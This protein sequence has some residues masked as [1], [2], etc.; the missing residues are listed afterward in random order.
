[1][2]TNPKVDWYFEK[3][4]KWQNEVAK[5]R[6][7]IL[8]CGLAEELKW[9]CPCY[10]EHKNNIVLI[11]TFNEYCA[12]L[13]FKGVLLKDTE[14]IL[15]QQTENVQAARQ[16]RFTSLQQINDLEVILKAHIFEAIEVERAGLKVEMKKTTEFN[17]PEEFQIKL[18]ENPALK[19]AFEALTPGR[20]RGYLLH[21]SQA[22]QAKTR[23]ARIEKNIDRIFEGKG[24]ED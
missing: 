22:K 21:F 5:L 4:G 11:H 9:G 19:S 6:T 12:L 18:N 13:F 14:G 20:Q 3:A 8:G 2:E 15:V 17:T 23:E 1:M 16:I 7:I 10:T 24:L